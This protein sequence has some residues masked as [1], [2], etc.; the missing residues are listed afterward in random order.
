MRKTKGRLSHAL[1]V[2]RDALLVSQSHGAPW[3]GLL[4]LCSTT[5]APRP[6]HSHNCLKKL[7]PADQH[8]WAGLT[9]DASLRGHG[10]GPKGQSTHRVCTLE[11]RTNQGQSSLYSA[12]FQ[13]P[14]GSAL[15]HFQQCEMVA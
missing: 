9:H 1:G 8:C 11:C 14:V 10:G 3:P 5:P 7:H 12:M 2:F 13:Q 4:V 15:L 6:C